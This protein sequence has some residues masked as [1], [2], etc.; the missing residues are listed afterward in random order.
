[1]DKM[2]CDMLK[3]N[4]ELNDNKNTYYNNIL[5]QFDNIHID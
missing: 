2:K 4:T 5:E 1:M 3:E